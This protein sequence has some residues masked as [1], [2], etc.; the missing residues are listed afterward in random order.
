MMAF[1][2]FHVVVAA[3]N[4]FRSAAKFGVAMQFVT[5][6]GGR[7][8]L[9]TAVPA[10]SSVFN[11]CD[12]DMKGKATVATKFIEAGAIV[13]REKPL[14]ELI[15]SSGQKLGSTNEAKL[16]SF[17]DILR[18]FGQMT[19]EEQN[20]YLALYG[21][22][23]TSPRF[24]NMLQEV[25]RLTRLA[26]LT[27]TQAQKELSARVTLIIHYNWFDSKHVPGEARVY[28]VAKSFLPFVRLQL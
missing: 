9:D 24:R 11:V 15:P 7:G 8:P 5:S 27:T 13:H 10:G 3:A 22:N 14:L 6:K 19:L 20:R 21:G 25:T 1:R 17:V 4:A 26:G 18:T 12:L 16:Q 28:D 23:T 2:I